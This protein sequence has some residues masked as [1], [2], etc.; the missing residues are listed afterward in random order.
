MTLIF[1]LFEQIYQ[2]SV[3]PEIAV[4]GSPVD[5]FTQS[6][7]RGI[8][9]CRFSLGFD[10][11]ES[12]TPNWSNTTT[13]KFEVGNNII[14]HCFTRFILFLL[15]QPFCFHVQH[16]KPINNE[17]RSIRSDVDGFPLTHR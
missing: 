1:F 16:I 4:H 8:N 2:H 10:I 13:I 6:G 7:S 12:L 14:A 9:L 3:T 17:G 5:N 11:G 15:L